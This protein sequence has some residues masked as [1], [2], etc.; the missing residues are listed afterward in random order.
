MLG[1]LCQY[2]TQARAKNFQPMKANFGLFPLPQ[3]QLNKADRYR[4]YSQRAL[5]ALR[6]FARSYGLE[7]IAVEV[8]GKSPK[9]AH[10][11]ELI[12]MGRREQY[13]D[14]RVQ[15]VGRELTE[16]T[17]IVAIH[18]CGALTD[19]SLETARRT[20][21]WFA[22][23]PCAA[24]TMVSPVPQRPASSVPPSTAT[25]NVSYLVPMSSGFHTPPTGVSVLGVGAEVERVAVGVG[26]V[27]DPP[28][29]LGS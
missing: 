9:P 15:R 20:G 1:A 2:V 21:G 12:E 27:D 11:Q 5:T 23:M 8:E 25:S 16:G 26:Q 29:G 18:A 4:W 6:R 10:L 19:R 28:I 14:G 13:R 17:A 3:H 7:Q 24:T 22:V